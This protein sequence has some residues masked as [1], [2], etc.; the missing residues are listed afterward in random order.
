MEHAEKGRPITLVAL[1]GLGITSIVINVVG[2]YL[3]IPQ[4][5]NYIVAAGLFFVEIVAFMALVNVA[6]DFAQPGILPKVKAG[7]S[8]V[9]FLA[10]C[11]IG[12]V[13][14]HRSLSEVD[15]LMSAPAQQLEATAGS[16]LAQAEA[17]ER[18][19][20]AWRDNAVGMR[21]YDMVTAAARLE[22]QALAAERE[23]I[24]LRASAETN[25]AEASATPALGGGI[26][27]MLL[28]VNEIAKSFGR[29]LFAFPASWLA[30]RERKVQEEAPAVAAVQEAEPLVLTNVVEETPVPAPARRRVRQKDAPAVVGNTPGY[31]PRKRVLDR[32]VDP[33]M[34]LNTL[35]DLGAPSAAIYQARALFNASGGEK[36]GGIYQPPETVYAN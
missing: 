18:Q 35:I 15:H 29:F 5:W 12:V 22:T 9:V 20:A 33:A 30:R 1:I 26:I 31:T 32:K 27:L 14:G 2:A 28:I 34:I 17:L 23:A 10:M 4:P 19:A 24:S 16:E 3:L 25:A 11:A 21:Q 13:S 7:L 8:F 6:K 36:I